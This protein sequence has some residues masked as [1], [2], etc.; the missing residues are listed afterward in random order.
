MMLLQFDPNIVTKEHLRK[1]K[2]QEMIEK[3][4]L[5]EY[6]EQDKEVIWKLRNECC[7]H[8]PQSLPKLLTCLRW[9]NH[10]NVAIVRPCC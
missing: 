5:H 7:Y 4:P 8:F 2:L 9:D 6:H 3:D 10:I 1:L